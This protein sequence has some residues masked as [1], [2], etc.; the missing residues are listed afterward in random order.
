MLDGRIIAVLAAAWISSIAC[1]GSDDH[2]RD[3]QPRAETASAVTTPAMAPA[4]ASA[5]EE[6]LPEGDIRIVATNGGI[7]L[8]LLGDSISSGLSPE[9]LRKVKE[10][11]D[12]AKVHGTGFGADLE[13]MVKGTVQGAVGKRVAFPLSEVRAV[14]YDGERIVF[15]WT[16]EPRKIFDNAKIDGKPLLASFAPEDARRFADAVN[17][18]KGRPRH[19]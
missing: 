8:A 2:T 6:V 10:E 14:R 15:E 17:A 18:R 4:S 3:E 7:D 13:K 1:S 19:L 16:R 11:T 12:T 9:A 5:E